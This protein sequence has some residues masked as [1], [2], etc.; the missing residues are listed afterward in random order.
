[1]GCCTQQ[2]VEIKAQSGPK[3]KLI[4]SK[5]KE[6]K[7]YGSNNNNINNKENKN[8]D[9]N[10]NPLDEAE[11]VESYDLKKNS[12]EELKEVKSDKDIKNPLDDV[13]EVKSE[14]II[15]T[16]YDKLKENKSDKDIKNPL[17]EAEE[18]KSEFIVKNPLDKEA[19]K[20]IEIPLN[21]EEIESDKEVNEKEKSKYPIQLNIKFEKNAGIRDVTELSDEKIA[22]ILKDAKELRIYSLKDGKLCNTFKEKENI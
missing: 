19:K 5:N 21:K 14:F 6:I 9:E 12:K 2:G 11:E 8:D 3:S 22:V 15:K 4:N 10:K 13:E 7:I 18:V 20:N 16:P 1:M 17:D